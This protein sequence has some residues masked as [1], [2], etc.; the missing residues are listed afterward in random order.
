MSLLFHFILKHLSMLSSL[1]HT[2]CT[3]TVYHNNFL[4]LISL[5]PK[6]SRSAEI[7]LLAIAKELHTARAPVSSCWM[8]LSAVFDTVNNQML[9]FTLQERGLS[10]STLSLFT[11]CTSRTALKERVNLY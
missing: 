11:Y 3:S 10:G 2:F 7:A 9:N 5:V 8:D 1:H 4:D 6:A